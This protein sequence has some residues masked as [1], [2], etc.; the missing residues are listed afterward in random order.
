MP[1]AVVA[2]VGIVLFAAVVALTCLYGIAGLPTTDAIPAVVC[3]TLLGLVT[4]L[5]RDPLA[6]QASGSISFVPFLA[7]ALLVPNIAAISTMAV[8]VLISE[9]KRKKDRIKVTFNLAQLALSSSVSILVYRSVGGQG[10]LSMSSAS[11]ALFDIP[12]AELGR[13]ALLPLTFLTIN[14]LLVSGVIA[15]HERRN[16]INVWRQNYAATVMYDVAAL[17]FVFMLAA[18]FAGWGTLATFLVATPLYGLRTLY[19]T[20][21]QLERTNHELL[22]LMVAAIE[23]R[24]LYTSGH[25]RRVSDYSRLIAVAIGLDDREADR[26]ARAGLLHDVGKIHEVFAPILQKPG[27]LSNEERLIMESHPIKSAELI[28]NVSHLHDILPAVRYH[29]ENW[30]GTGYPEGLKGE[31]IPLASRIIMLADTIDAMTTDRPYRA[32]LGENEVRIEL[33]RWSGSQFDPGL[34]EKLL[35]SP[36]FATLFARLPKYNRP[37]LSIMRGTDADQEAA[38][39]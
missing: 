12:V 14:A 32:A 38:T 24:D 20:K 3:F 33:Q 22:E 9:L 34:C 10:L 31:G 30:D 26:V 1:R 25:S 11:S 6:K 28:Q 17:P 13:G 19:S 23:A 7:T 4:Q 37:T 2:Y 18:V 5:L 36:K 21:R 35:N 29:H 15:T 8:A 27:K 39:A 16:V